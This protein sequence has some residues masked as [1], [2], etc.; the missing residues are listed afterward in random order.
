MCRYIHADDPDASKLPDSIPFR[1]LTDIF[2]RECILINEINSPFID[3]LPCAACI[4]VFGLT[5]HGK[6]IL[7]NTLSPLHCFESSGYTKYLV[8]IS[9]FGSAIQHAHEV[10]IKN[11]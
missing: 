4:S 7:Y 3:T 8:D 11:L 9:C 5:S 6:E 2:G 10:L 1:C